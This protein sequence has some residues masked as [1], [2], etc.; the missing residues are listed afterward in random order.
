MRDKLKDTCRKH[1]L[2]SFSMKGCYSNGI[3]D[4]TSI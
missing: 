3:L 1:N 2:Y 4:T